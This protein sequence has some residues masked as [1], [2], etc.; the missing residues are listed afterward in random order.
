MPI[1]KIFA[2]L[3]ERHL[4]LAL[5]M[6]LHACQIRN[7]EQILGQ[8]QHLAL[9]IMSIKT[10]LYINATIQGQQAQAAVA[11]HKIN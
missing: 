1:R 5:T 11:I 4:H 10:K 7:A 6:Q 2:M 3:L 9:M 8:A